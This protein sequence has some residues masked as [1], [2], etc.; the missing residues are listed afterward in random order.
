MR[1]KQ[2]QIDFKMNHYRNFKNNYIKKEILFI[3]VL[4]CIFR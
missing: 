3:K 4:T 1:I 2:Y